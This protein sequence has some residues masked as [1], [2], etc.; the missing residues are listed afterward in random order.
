MRNANKSPKI[1]YSAMVRKMEKWYGIHIGTEMKSS[2]Y[3]LL[4]EWQIGR[5]NDH[6][7]S[8]LLAEVITYKQ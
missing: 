4:A 7:T 1:P 8:T 3:F 6:I 2:E 5:Q